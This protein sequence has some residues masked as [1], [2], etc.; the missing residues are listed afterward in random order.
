[1]DKVSD[2]AAELLVP[3]VEGWAYLDIAN[4]VIDVNNP[5]GSL[6]YPTTVRKFFTIGTLDE[7]G[8]ESRNIGMGNGVR[9]GPM[10]FA[11]F[12]RR[13]THCFE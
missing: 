5:E 7:R 2:V 13:V 4:H 3:F 1:M 6:R 9:I 12:E 8:D 11:N 10:V